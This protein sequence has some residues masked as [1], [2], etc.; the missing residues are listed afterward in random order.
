MANPGTT[1]T[2]RRLSTRSAQGLPSA[3]R[4][5]PP[6]R[7]ALRAGRPAVRSHRIGHWADEV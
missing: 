2:P 7:C 4:V 3:G 5:V 6:S 1:A